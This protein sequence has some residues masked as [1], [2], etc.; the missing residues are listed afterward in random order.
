[1]Y[2][3]HFGLTEAPFKI[4]PNTEFFFTGGNRGAILEALSYAIKEGEGIIKVV[5]E[6]GSGKTMICR[7]LQKTLP[8][9]IESIYLAIPSVE[10]EH[11]LKAIAF[12]L[13]MRLPKDADRIK[14]LQRLQSYLLKR[15][16]KGQQTVIFVEEAQAMPIATLEEI[17][18][19][20]N[21]E[22][23]QDKLLQIVL[24][25]Q[26]ELDE[27]LNK[28][29]I[30]QL[31]DRITHSFELG[32][33]EAD[34]IGEYLLFRLR[35]AGYYGPQLFNEKSIKKIAAAS[36]G[37]L[38]R[39]NILADKSLLSAFSENV[40]HV[41]PVQ[42]K[43]AIDDSEFA[44]NP[45]QNFKAL[46]AVAVVGLVLLAAILFANANKTKQPTKAATGIVTPKEK[47][48]VDA[49]KEAKE[50]VQQ[51]NENTITESP[52]SVA[53]EV[54]VPSTYTL[55]TQKTYS[56]AMLATKLDASHFTI[57]IM[58]ATNQ[59]D[60]NRIMKKISPDLTL[61]RIFLFSTPAPSEQTIVLYGDYADR[62]SATNAM[63]LL[64]KTVK[65]HQPF[66][67]TFEQIQETT[68][69]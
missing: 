44:N 9:E 36:E 16:A 31:R 67:R 53:A 2:Y 10:P 66:L 14:I 4:T 65:S 33:L 62:T 69:P 34:E 46:I 68:Q 21:L 43:A 24:F 5:G 6:V 37:L 28:S 57:Q 8:E 29:D 61:S 59:Q 64:P 39:V 23:N 1:M 51:A 45:T 22:T 42:V 38:R 20:S 12:E 60:V 47:V 48:R 11:V 15:H 26:P 55:D 3:P 17:R 58:T 54:V 35:A 7:M 49:A 13:N 18:L 30:R 50:I 32:P 25:G 40:Y 19:L 63:A 41:T 52:N 56:Q 27:N